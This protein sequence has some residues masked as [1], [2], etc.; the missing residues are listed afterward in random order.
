MKRIIIIVAV[1]ILAAAPALAD[2]VSD[3]IS[4]H[5]FNRAAAGAAEIAGQPE[6]K[7]GRYTY[8]ASDSVDIIVI[9][10]G[11]E[12]KSVS[13]V[14]LDDSG[15]GEFLAQ[16]AT[17]FYDLGGLESYIYCY[18]PLLTNFLSARAG[19]NAENDSSVPGL[20]FGISKESFGYMFII[21]KVK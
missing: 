4:I 20:L 1:L 2:P 16:C 8:H 15:V 17:V 13:C 11:N 10:D 21:V 7:D 12:I 3:F 6:E 19:R 14:C 9:T 18:D 5:N